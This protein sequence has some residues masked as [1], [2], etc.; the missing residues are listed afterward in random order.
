MLYLY[1]LCLLLFPFAI[2]VYKRFLAFRNYYAET[3]YD[4]IDLA[5]FKAKQWHRQVNH[6][7][8]KKPYSVH[9]EGVV[10]VAMR[11][12]HCIPADIFDHI[13]A[14]CWLHDTIEDTRKTYNDVRD[15][16]GEMVANIVYAVSNE[17]GKSRRERANQ[18]YYLGILK[19]YGADLVKMFDRVAN[20]EYS[21]KEKSRMFEMYK[22]EN[23]SF[24]DHFYF[25]DRE[26]LHP[27]I[28]HLNLLCA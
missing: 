7:Y 15:M 4:F 18:K 27:I 2:W 1:L 11:F 24:V 5:R 19:T 8:G 17:K 10:A 25:N 26:Y 12:R 9:L 23:V 13:I 6:R 28:R 14:A 3:F 20:V 16:F 21:K 22:K